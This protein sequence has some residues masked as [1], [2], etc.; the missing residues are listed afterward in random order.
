VEIPDPLFRRAQLIAAQRGISFS[1]VVTQALAENLGGTA[2]AD[3][4]WMKSFGKLRRLR[5]ENTRIDRIIRT[6]F[7]VVEAEDLVVTRSGY[8]R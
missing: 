3:K 1:E 2:T 8:P 5:R 4:P 7:G 6:E